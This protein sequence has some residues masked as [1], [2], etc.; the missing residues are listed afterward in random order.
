MGAGNV[1]TL[2]LAPGYSRFE[3]FCAEAEILPELE[4]AQ[5]MC[6]ETNV[7]SDDEG[8]DSDDEREEEIEDPRAF[9]S[10]PVPT[11]FD[12]DG[13]TPEG[14]VPVIIEDEEDRQVT[15]DAAL[16]LQYHQRFSHISPA[17]IQL[18]AK[19]G[20]IPKQLAHCAIPVCS[21]CLYG[22]ASKQP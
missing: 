17:K 6:F 1:A 10:E 9:P 21:A 7:I 14:A 16:F 18:M 13:P 15:S 12:L 20:I 3:A 22:K 5:P 4:D 2:R 11:S 19:S 8:G